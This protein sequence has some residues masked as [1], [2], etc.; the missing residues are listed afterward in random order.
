[1]LNKQMSLSVDNL[2][3]QY[4]NNTNGKRKTKVSYDTYFIVW[5]NNIF[6][7]Q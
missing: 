6:I 3:R 5:R 1:M 7:I 2:S 4:L